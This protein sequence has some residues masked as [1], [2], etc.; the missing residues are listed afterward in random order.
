MRED[1][2][3]TYLIVDHHVDRTMC[4]VGG[5]LTQ[6]EGLI[7][8]PLTSEGCISM[9]QDGHDLTHHNQDGSRNM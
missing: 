2:S 5:E 3:R 7:D 4:G 6:V 8:H 9:D 1:E